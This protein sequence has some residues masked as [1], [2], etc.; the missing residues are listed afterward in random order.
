MKTLSYLQ[1]YIFMFIPEV[2]R[3]QQ[4]FQEFVKKFHPDVL[5]NRFRNFR[6]FLITSVTDQKNSNQ[7]AA[8]SSQQ[9]QVL[10]SEESHR[11]QSSTNCFLKRSEL[12]YSDKYPN[13][14]KESYSTSD[15][16]SDVIK[17][18]RRTSWN[19]MDASVPDVIVQKDETVNTYDKKYFENGSNNNLQIVVNVEVPS[20]RNKSPV[21]VQEWVDSLPLTPNDTSP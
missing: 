1:G 6:K 16:N 18:N 12:K 3:T 20:S 19:A 14:D 9:T 13:V 15:G 10:S 4:R 5:R 8:T 7:E 21:T 2:G 11:L 17:V